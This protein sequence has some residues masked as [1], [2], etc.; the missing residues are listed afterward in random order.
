MSDLLGRISGLNPQQMSTYQQAV[1]DNNINGTVLSVCDLDDLGKCL[2]MKFGDWQLFRS[3]IQALR[4]AEK[5]VSADSS[6]ETID[7]SSQAQKPVSSG[8]PSRSIHF[9]T[10][11]SGSCIKRSE[12]DVVKRKRS[13]AFKRQPSIE[14]QR[15]GVLGS[16]TGFDA[17][18]EE[19]EESKGRIIKRQSISRKDSFVEQAMYESGLLHDFVHTFTEAVSEEDESSGNISEEMDRDLI[20]MSGS[21][22]SLRKK[23]SPVEFSLSIG[24]KPED[25]N[26]SNENEVEKEPLLPSPEA[27]SIFRSPTPVLKLPV[28]KT[29]ESFEKLSSNTQSVPDS[30]NVHQ[31]EVTVHQELLPLIPVSKAPS[32][33]SSGFTDIHS[34]AEQ[35]S[36]KSVESMEMLA[37]VDETSVDSKSGVANIPK[38]VSIEESIEQYTRRSLSGDQ[39]SGMSRSGSGLRVQVS[40]LKKDRSSPESFV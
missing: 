28:L 25:E 11:E 2:Q 12:D 24:S 35:G 6:S 29:L 3:A 17:I 20:D 13:T 34:D 32:T 19:P 4:D 16:A 39:A 1:I 5:C 31:S 36:Q 10:A 9:S 37:I 27:G 30:K 33:A 15:D 26:E 38:S 21:K 8:E 22:T 40:G 18:V 14:T 23:K 7:R